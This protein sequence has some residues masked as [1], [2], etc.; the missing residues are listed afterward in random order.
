M[1]AVDALDMRLVR[2]C[3][4]FP[5]ARGA[6]ALEVLRTASLAGAL[7]TTRQTVE[8]RLARL[9][10]QG[11]IAGYPV[12][13]N[14]RHLGLHWEIRHWRAGARERSAALRD[15]PLRDGVVG[16]YSFLGGDLCVDLLWRAEEDRDALLGR[17]AALAGNMPPLTLYS[18]QMPPV[19][20]SLTRLDWRILLALR[21]D[22]RRSLDEVARE[23]GVSARTVKRHLARMTRER[24]FDVT[25]QVALDR[26]RRTIPLAMLV[27]FTPEGG[28]RTAAELVR[29][30]DDRCLAAWVPPSPG[31]GHWDM[32]L[33]AESPAEI[34]EMRASA[35]RVPG[36]ARVE[37]LLYTGARVDAA[38][39]DEQVRERAEGTA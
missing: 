39:L 17:V 20:G 29:T 10:E 7:G 25:A 34:E 26:A 13:P 24:A 30:F 22:A 1:R 21:H 11:I 36:V 35:E 19:E 8:A 38:W 3:G 6:R 5:F 31:L 23:V 4:T 16:V 33:C 37:L 27:H 12:W 28:R 9:E 32:S 2:E 15:L 18:R 14:L